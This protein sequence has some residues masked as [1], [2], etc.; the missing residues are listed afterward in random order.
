MGME[1]QYL[2]DDALDTEVGELRGEH[3]EVIS[4]SARGAKS[5]AKLCVRSRGPQAPAEEGGTADPIINSDLGMEALESASPVRPLEVEPW[6]ATG[7]MCD[8]LAPETW[9]DPFT[10]KVAKRHEAQGDFPIGSTIEYWSYQ[11]GRWIHTRVLDFH[12]ICGLY[13]LDCHLR[14]DPQRLR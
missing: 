8:T 1:V 14:A 5:L 3:P 9:D 11:H 2:G 13:D 7:N 4:R 10:F 6:E 12:P